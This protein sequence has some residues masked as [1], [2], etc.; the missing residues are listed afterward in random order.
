MT[1][2]GL[3]IGLALAAALAAIG[4]MAIL[5][6][7]GLVWVSREEK[8]GELELAKETAEVVS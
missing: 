2:S 3:Q 1:H 6:G 5:T 8:I 4:C 7:L